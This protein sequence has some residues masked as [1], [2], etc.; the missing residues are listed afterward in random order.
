MAW[1]SFKTNRRRSFIIAAAV[2]LSAFMLFSV[3]TVGVTY[4][5]MH[6]LQ[7][8]RMNGAEYDAI[9]YGLTG[10][11]QRLCEENPDIAAAGIAAIAGYTIETEEDSTVDVNFI[12]ADDTYWNT[13]MKPAREW[14]EGEYPTAVNEIMVTREALQEC[15]LETLGIGDTLKVKYMDERGTH[16]EEF[17]ITGMWGGY[18]TK[19]VFYVS[20]AFYE[21]SGKELSSVSSGRCYIDFKQRLMT[22]KSQDEFISSMNLEKQQNLIFTADFGY[23]VEIFAGMAGLILITCFCAYLLIYN[24]MYLSVSG[25]IRYYGLLQTVGMTGKQIYQLILKQVLITGGLG[26][27]GGILL[28][29]VVSLFVIPKVI[30]LLGIHVGG[31]EIAFHPAIFLLTILLAGVTVYIGSRKPVRKAVAV[32]PI[33]AAGYRPINGKKTT[34]KTGKGRLLWRLAVE[35]LTKDKKKS[36]IVILSLASGLSVFL[37]LAALIQSQGP[38]TIVS[39]S[40]NVDLTVEN[41]TLKKENRDEWIQ[42]LDETFLDRIKKNTGVQEV[43][44]I[45]SAEITVPWEPDFSDIWMRE[46]YEMWMTEPYEDDIV[47]YQ[48]HPENFGSFILG[49]SEGEL[50]YLNESLPEPIDKKRFLKG[51]TCI[52]Y[53]NGLAFEINDLKGKQVTCA[54]YADAGN[55]RSFEIAGLSDDSY[56]MGALLGFPPT[57]IASDR[58]VAEFISEPF[59]YKAGIFYNQEYDE[60]VET[61]IL[62]IIQENAYAKDFSY[63]S[64]LE[65]MKILK[66]AQGNMMEVGIGI[67]LILALIGIL[68]YINTVTGN[69]QNRQVELAVM[70]SIGMTGKQ[71][72][73]ML[74]AEG[75]LFA[76]CSLLLTATLGTGITYLIYQSMNFYGAAFVIPVLPVLGMAVFVT[77]LCVAVPLVARYGLEKKT[78]VV[79]RIKRFE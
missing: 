69:I 65:D 72:N 15:G 28:G 17:C 60:Q 55:T 23:S 42:L 38:R 79:E 57:I 18:G 41:R 66:R 10:E 46:F 68:N 67:V 32:S 3:L 64:K 45:L 12:W 36:V 7:N 21:R 73:H 4:F 75:M 20:E 49:I 13:M 50:D 59:V 22:Q 6:R 76:V 52:L 40:Q 39:G 26:I 63:E 5:K 71:L 48:E 62:E 61:E 58:V 47:E 70:E 14:V 19:R 54:E 2:L 24:I 77:V 11:Q 34:R 16:T 29:S 30:K 35:Q 43:T 44:P 74:M 78:S 56:Y 33:E 51:E 31:I 37:C 25:N 53:R 8:I 1:R 27:T 9:V